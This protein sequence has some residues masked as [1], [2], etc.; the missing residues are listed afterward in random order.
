MH[1]YLAVTDNDWFHFLR[2]KPELEEVNFWQLLEW[3][4]DTRFRG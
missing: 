3:H 2:S 1:T 4:A